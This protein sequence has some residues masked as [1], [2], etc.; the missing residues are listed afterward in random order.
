MSTYSAKPEDI[1]RKW[2]LIDA[3]DLV[4]GRMASIVSEASG[5]VRS[6]PWISAPI[7]GCN[8]RMV[9]PPRVSLDVNVMAYSFHKKPVNSGD[10][11]QFDRA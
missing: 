5:P 3:E 11:N 2:F 9:S 6:I 1:T 7:I 4:L 10:D 8:L